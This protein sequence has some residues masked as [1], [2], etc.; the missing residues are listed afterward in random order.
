MHFVYNSTYKPE[1]VYVGL[2]LHPFY[3]LLLQYHLPI[4]TIL[5]S[6]FQ[7]NALCLAVFFDADPLF[8]MRILFFI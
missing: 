3:A 7:F 6:H 1:A 5:L 4:Y 2:V 8:Q